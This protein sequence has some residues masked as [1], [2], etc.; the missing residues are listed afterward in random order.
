[1]PAGFIAAY[2]W[3]LP[4]TSSQMATLVL[5]GDILQLVG[6]IFLGF[7][8]GAQFQQLEFQQVE[9][10][11]KHNS[12]LPDKNSPQH[13]ETA[14]YRQGLKLIFGLIVMGGCLCWYDY[15][16]YMGDFFHMG[17]G[18][19]LLLSGVNLP[20]L[21]AP[22][23]WVKRKVNALW[24]RG[25]SYLSRHVTAFYVIQWV[26]IYWFMAFF[27]YHQQNALNT[28][29]IGGLMFVLTLIVLR[30]WLLLRAFGVRLFGVSLMPTAKSQ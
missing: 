16:Y 21:W 10:Q 13:R 7:Y 26:L 30:A 12:L 24:V 4:L 22:N 6:L 2:G 14:L 11:Q 17:P 3:S 28:L 29:A 20:V 18:G 27:G 25:L 23:L 8:L 1:M 15:Q 5:L 9:Q 19:I